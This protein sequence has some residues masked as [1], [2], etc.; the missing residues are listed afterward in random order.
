MCHASSPNYE[1]YNYTILQQA[2]EANTERHLIQTGWQNVNWINPVQDRE[3]W[4]AL[5]NTVMN[6]RAP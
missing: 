6:L 1:A 3:K 4:H 5:V 2:R